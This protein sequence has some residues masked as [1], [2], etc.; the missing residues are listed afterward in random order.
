MF[1]QQIING[2]VAGSAYALF[3]LGFVLM[4]GVPGIINLTYRFYVP[5]GAHRARPALIRHFLTRGL[6]LL[7]A[8]ESL[9][10]Q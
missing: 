2:F 1:A 5:A 6:L 4:F 8:G 3:A 7:H 9:G 10:M